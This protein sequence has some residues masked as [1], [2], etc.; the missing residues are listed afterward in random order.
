MLRYV[1]CNVVIMMAATAWLMLFFR[2]C[3]VCAFLYFCCRNVRVKRRDWVLEVE[4]GSPTSPTRYVGC[5]TLLSSSLPDHPPSALSQT[6]ILHGTWKCIFCFLFSVY[7]SAA[8][9]E[10]T[11]KNIMK[12]KY[13]L[14]LERD[15][16]WHDMNVFVLYRVGH[17]KV[18][19]VRNIAW[20]RCSHPETQRPTTATNHVSRISAV[21]RM[22]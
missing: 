21:H 19:R 18:A 2:S 5:G 4:G 12:F 8:N 22:Q 11:R 3:I 9:G 13:N 6:S 1:R 14:L 20:I 7:H 16:V 15:T 17:E 10:R